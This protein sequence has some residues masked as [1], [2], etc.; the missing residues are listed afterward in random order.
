[1]MYPQYL[2]DKFFYSDDF[3]EEIGNKKMK[4][5]HSEMVLQKIIG[6]EFASY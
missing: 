1:M 3:D 2:N 5:I 4:R 6:L